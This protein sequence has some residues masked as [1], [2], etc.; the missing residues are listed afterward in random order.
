MRALLALLLACCAAVLS[1]RAVHTQDVPVGASE[2]VA[3]RFTVVAFPSEARLARSLLDAAVSNDTF[4]GL[5]R[6]SAAVRI[7]LAP[8]DDRFREW[9]GPLA[10]EWGAA[11]AFPER[12]LIVMQG[13]NAGAD[14]GD[15]LVTL[16]HELAHLVLHEMLG[17][18]VPRWFDEG[19]ASYSA[20]EWGREELFATSIGLVWRGVPTL[21]G[22]D[23]G[24]Y[25]GA[26]RAE[27]SYAIA[28]RAVAELASIDPD[29][30]LTL[31]FSHWRQEETFERAL[32]RAHGLS[33]TEFEKLYRSRVRR[34]FG[35]LALAA[36]VTILSAFLV[37]LLGP[38]WYRRR[39]R[40]RARLE[41]LRAADL[42]QE[43]RERE[44]ALTALLGTVVPEP[45]ADD[46]IKGS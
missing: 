45:P 43:A 26:G 35:A 37:F 33:G 23:S 16:R 1:P 12:Q 19:Y 44:S 22:L 32:R 30:G 4:P 31:L 34:Q 24:F 41:R 20:G 17:P 9:V 14:A 25:A 28:H 21:A 46:R 10:P 40:Q 15:P 36:D 2:L 5:P 13:T 18:A 7:L 3:S 42:A 38:L 29:K 11:I 27:R 6:P 39:A 8:D